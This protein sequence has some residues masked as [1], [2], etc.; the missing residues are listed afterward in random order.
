M[1]R[2]SFDDRFRMK[3]HT[4]VQFQND[5]SASDS[6]IFFKDDPSEQNPYLNR[7]GPR[8]AYKPI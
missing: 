8:Q 7:F 5:Q 3:G 1:V 2:L 6:R 4:G